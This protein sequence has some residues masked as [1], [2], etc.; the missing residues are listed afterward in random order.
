M[1]SLPHLPPRCPAPEVPGALS[2]AICHL[3]SGPEMESEAPASFKQT[4]KHTHTFHSFSHTR[5]HQFTDTHTLYFIYTPKYPVYSHTHIRVPRS[6]NCQASQLLLFWSPSRPVRC[7]SSP[8]PSQLPFS[9]VLG[10]AWT[11][12]SLVQPQKG[13]C[14]A[15]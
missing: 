8:V 1:G 2:G 15:S 11:G 3:S 6:E 13:L 4:H 14:T 12:T 9:W 10:T 7:P 5:K